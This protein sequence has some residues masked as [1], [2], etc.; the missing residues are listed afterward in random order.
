MKFA[1]ERDVL[2]E[3]LGTAGRA[4]A[5]R[6]GSLPVLAGVR[7]ELAGDRLRLTG[8]DLEL[9]ITVEATVAGETDG[10]AVLQGRIA[11]DL[12]KS[13]E[14]G[15]VVVTAEQDE[16]HISAGRFSM[17]FRSL[18]QLLR[19]PISQLET[20]TCPARFGSKPIGT[21]D[22][23]FEEERPCGKDFV[24]E[25]AERL[26]EKPCCVTLVFPACPGDSSSRSSS[27]SPGR[28]TPRPA[29]SLRSR[30]TSWS[31]CIRAATRTTS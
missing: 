4:V 28:P 31:S 14:A 17:E 5:T 19:Q 24:W 20:L 12:V 22:G 26:P 3:A 18:K 23:S 15:R 10:V 6:G 2:V 11:A 30:R 9:T 1:C 8:T 29:A 13:L 25:G 7:F 21:N 16:A 27:R